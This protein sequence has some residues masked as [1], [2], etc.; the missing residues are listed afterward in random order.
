MTKARILLMLILLT[1]TGFLVFFVFGEAVS[2]TKFAQVTVYMT[3][4]QVQELLGV[5]DRVRV[6]TPTTTAFFYGGFL[7]FRF[8]TMEVCFGTNGCVTGK[9]HDH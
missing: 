8:C 4:N 9:F 2:K 6:D 5:P 7:R 3:K 1:V